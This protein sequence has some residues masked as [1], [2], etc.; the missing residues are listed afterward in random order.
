[1][2]DEGSDGAVGD[3]SDAFTDWLRS[4]SSLTASERAAEAF[5]AR[6]TA[7]AH[8]LGE[9]LVAGEGNRPAVDGPVV[10]GVWLSWGLL[11]VGQTTNAARRL[12]DLPIGESHHLSNTFPPELWERVVAISWPTLPGASEAMETLGSST[13]GL[14]LEYRLLVQANPLVNRSRRTR[15]G[16]WRSVEYGRSQSSGAMAA[17]NVGALFNSLWNVWTVAADAKDEADLP[18]RTVR[19]VFPRRLLT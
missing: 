12:R 13:V 8:Q 3:G 11:Y 4:L 10:Y 7:F 19:L 5:R 16:G 17:N 6:R 1:M 9:L 15:T 2:A 14:A 18:A